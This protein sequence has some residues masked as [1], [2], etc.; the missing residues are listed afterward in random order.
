[1]V[2]FNRFFVNR[3][4]PMKIGDTAFAAVAYHK[5]NGDKIPVVREED[6]LVLYRSGGSQSTWAVIRPGKE[7]MA[8]V[9]IMGDKWQ[10]T[11]PCPYDAGVEM[12]PIRDP[13]R[14]AGMLGS[15]EVRLDL[16]KWFR[17]SAPEGVVS[18]FVVRNTTIESPEEL[19]KEVDAIIAADPRSYRG[20]ESESFWEDERERAHILLGQGREA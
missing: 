12:T 6:G 18:W 10:E 7:G 5:M 14:V 4:I 8:L 3:N 16:N 1:M 17:R 13:Y 9:A 15:P 19:Q 2:V 11:S 20:P